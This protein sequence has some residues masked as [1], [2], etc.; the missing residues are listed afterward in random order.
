M[1]SVE[2]IQ[3]CRVSF[4]GCDSVSSFYG[5]GKKKV[6]QT[7]AKKE[8]HLD[9]FTELGQKFPPSRD[10]IQ[11]IKCFVCH[12]YGN[13]SVTSVNELRF[14]LFR[15]GKYEEESLPPTK[16]VLIQHILRA[17]FQAYIWRHYHVPMLNL[18]PFTSHGWLVVDQKLEVKWMENNVAPDSIL[19]IVNCKCKQPCDTKRCSCVKNGLQCSDLCCCS[20]CKNKK[21]D[22]EPDSSNDDD[23]E[24][25]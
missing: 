5:K 21:A 24:E 9:A 14:M 19:N 4:S 17:N 1:T 2:I 3:F 6:L 16:D 20:N 23:D 18:P 15:G 11:K 7:A 13:E 8:E 22:G 12:L 25:D 10:L